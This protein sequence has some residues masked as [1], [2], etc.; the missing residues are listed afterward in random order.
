MSRNKPSK[1]RKTLDIECAVMEIKCTDGN[2]FEERVYGDV[3][4]NELVRSA[5]FVVGD[6]LK[7][8]TKVYTHQK[9]EVYV[10]DEKGEDYTWL[11]GVSFHQV[12]S[13]SVK[14]IESF[15]TDLGEAE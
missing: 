6:R 11:S 14:R 15:V 5:R 4:E 10:S 7:S 1:A 13:Y 8:A 2:I 3:I 12:D 9:F